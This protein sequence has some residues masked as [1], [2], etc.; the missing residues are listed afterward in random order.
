MF[1]VKDKD[2]FPK[3]YLL[4]LKFVPSFFHLFVF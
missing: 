2:A 4:P 3:L 1:T